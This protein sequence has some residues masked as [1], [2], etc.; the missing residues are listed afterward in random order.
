MGIGGD[1]GDAAPLRYGPALYL[2]EVG[3][4]I[5][6]PRAA[7]VA[8]D[9]EAVDRRAAFNEPG[10]TLRVETAADKNTHMPETGQVQPGADLFDQ[11]DGDAAALAG[12]IEPDEI[13]PDTVR[14]TIGE[15]G[16]RRLYCYSHTF[17]RMLG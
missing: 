9:T 15:P 11:V 1:A 4:E 16:C 17:S 7:D 6:G 13:T 5:D 12:R 2:V 8:A 14:F 10:N 3:G